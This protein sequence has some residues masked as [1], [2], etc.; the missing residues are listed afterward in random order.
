M[1]VKIYYM[2]LGMLILA[3]CSKSIEV[4]DTPDFGVTTES[5]SFKAGEEIK[6]T[7][8][9]DNV[10]N[11]SFYSGETRK[12]YDFRNGRVVNVSDSGAIMAFQSSVQTGTQTNQITV[13]ASTDFNGDYS[14][15]AGVKA[16]TWTD[17]TSRVILGTN[18]T[19]KASGNVDITDIMIKGQPV[20]FAFKYMTLPQATNGLVR[21]WYFQVFAVTSKAKL[22]GTIALPLTDQASAG[23]RLVDENPVDAPALSAI[24]TTRVTLVGNRY[25]VDTDPLFDPDNPIFDPL[26]P[27]YDPKSPL[28]QPTA[29]RPTFVPFD[30]A[31][32]WNDPQSEHWAVSGPINTANVDLGPDWSTPLKGATTTGI[33][34][35]YRYKYTKP[36]TYKAVFIAANNSIDGVKQVVRELTLTITE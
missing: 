36:G 30:P 14:T 32:P 3:S 17:I 10:H 2:L 20:Y 27:I 29:V 1:K 12:D 25:K 19:F 15:L 7:F 35:E 22:D 21:T 18:A 26:N 24:T 28:Y 34:Q 23:F 11:I 6:F 33:M 16:A 5:T 8:T 31:S 4:G 13:L 9:G